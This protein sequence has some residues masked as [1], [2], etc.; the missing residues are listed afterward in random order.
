[1]TLEC[2]DGHYYEVELVCDTKEDLDELLALSRDVDG[3]EIGTYD[4]RCEHGNL[5]HCEEEE[6]ND[7]TCTTEE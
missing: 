4:A 6:D 5:E 1:M 2:C 7:Y 3:V